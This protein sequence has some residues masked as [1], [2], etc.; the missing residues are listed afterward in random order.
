MVAA[1]VNRS[2][3]QT[4]LASML[5][6]RKLEQLIALPLDHAALSYQGSLFSSGLPSGGTTENFYV[7]HDRPVDVG[8]VS[9]MQKGT[10]Q[11]SSTAFYEGQ[12]PSYIVQWVVLADN[13]T[14]PMTGLRRIIVRAESTSPGLT[15][16][17][18]GSN[19]TG[20]EYAQVSTIRTPAQ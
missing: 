9:V 20:R 14:I 6:K 10:G 19:L 15:G 13:A 3:R 17:G 2:S 8:G 18:P 5:A 16:M 7:D 12:S 11:I 1:V 4:T